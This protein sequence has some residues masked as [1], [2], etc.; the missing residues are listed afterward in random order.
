MDSC[1]FYKPPVINPNN[2]SRT[3][4][5]SVTSNREEHTVQLP[6]IPERSLFARS[7][8]YA[9]GVLLSV[10][11]RQKSEILYTEAFI[12]RLL[13]KEQPFDPDTLYVVRPNLP[14]EAQ[15]FS[16]SGAYEFL[17]DPHFCGTVD[18]SKTGII[19]WPEKLRING[20]LN[21]S[22]SSI[23]RLPKILVVNGDLN[24]SGCQNLKSLSEIK[25]V[26]DGKLIARNSGLRS[27]QSKLEANS[28]D[29][30]GS[31]DFGVFGSADQFTIAGEIILNGCQRLD[32]NLPNWLFT[33]GPMPDGRRR[34]IDLCN[35]GI[36]DETLGGAFRFPIDLPTIRWDGKTG[37]LRFDSLK[38]LGLNE[39]YESRA[40]GQ[41]AMHLP[42]Q[43]S[44]SSQTGQREFRTQTTATSESPAETE[45]LRQVAS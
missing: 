33:I 32:G 18:L 6:P 28:L 21:L 4:L 17:I 3:D 30:T 35:T 10:I 24:I 13:T 44:D 36:T 37:E 29:L 34:H 38:Q 11:N 14:E 26:V 27:I 15:A 40:L 5:E 42:Y 19:H 12:Q 2:E 7:I 23:D 20:S 39:A 45:K 31:T 1:S 25:T 9:Q 22:E 43:V 41:S 16:P 8:T